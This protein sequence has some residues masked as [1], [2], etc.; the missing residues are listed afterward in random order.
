MPAQISMCDFPD[1]SLPVGIMGRV[2]TG[3]LVLVGLALCEGLAAQDHG[4]ASGGDDP[5]RITDEYLPLAIDSFPDRPRP[6]LEL[7]NP[8]LGPGPL[9]DPILSPTGAFWNPSLLVWGTLRSGVTA[10]DRGNNDRSQWANRLD[11][12]AEARLSSTER[13]VVGLRPLDKDGE[14]TGYDFELDED[15]DGANLDVQ[16]AFIEGDFGEIFPGLDRDDASALD[17]GFGVGRQ[18]VSF[19]DGIMVNDVMDALTLTRNSIRWN[20]VSN[21]RATALFAW[22]EVH[23]GRAVDDEDSVIVGLLTALDFVDNYV[24]ADILFSTSSDDTIGDAINIGVG[25]TQRIGKMNSTFRANASIASED[26]SAAAADGLLLTSV[27]SWVPHHTHDNLYVA[28][29]AS[30]D[31]FTSAARGPA[32]GGPLSNIG[33]LF[34]ATGLGNVGAPISPRANEVI[35]GAVGYQQFLPPRPP[36]ADLRDRGPRGDRRSGMTTARSRAACATSKRSGSARWSFSTCLPGLMSLTT[37]FFG[38]PSRVPGQVLGQEARGASRGSKQTRAVFRVGTG[39]GPPR[40]AAT[41]ERMDK[42][43]I[44]RDGELLQEEELQPVTSIGRNSKCTIQFEDPQISRVHVVLTKRSAGYE[45]ADQGGMN[46]TYLNE[47]RLDTRETVMLKDGDVFRLQSFQVKL[48]A[49]PATPAAV[50]EPP[51]PEASPSETH[52]HLESLD[53]APAASILLTD[54]VEK[55]GSFPVWTKGTATLRVADIIKET[56][57]TNTFRLVGKEDTLF[58]YKPG[59]FVTISVEIEGKTVKRSYSISSSPSRPHTLELTVKRVPGGL[60][61]NWL[62]DNLALGDEL[63]IRGPAGKFSCFNY[64]SRRMLCIAGG[65]GI[66]PIMSMCRWIVDTTA[67]VD[68]T[69][70]YSVHIASGHHFPQGARAHLRAAQWL[71]GSSSRPLRAGW[72]PRLDR[73]DRAHQPLDAGLARAGSAGAS[74]LPLRAQAIQRRHQGRA[75]GARLSDREPAHRE[76]RCGARLRPRRQR[77]RRRARSRECGTRRSAHEEGHRDQAGDQEGGTQEGHC[78]KA[79]RKEGRRSKSRRRKAGGREGHI[80]GQRGCCS[81]SAS[82]VPAG[83]KVVFKKSGSEAVA[84]DDV[85]LLIWPS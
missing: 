12:F 19:Q 83:F 38:W 56:S 16:T 70:L 23:R 35:G 69:L 13:L 9:K 28:A 46:G 81:G 29:F 47:R 21:F 73:T 79:S 42:L 53:E 10:V 45:L 40:T 31:E 17:I 85:K 72:G 22:D 68:V 34:A 78:E 30:L 32:S 2:Q 36:A 14:F 71:G 44:E 82:P 6:I 54:L 49:R 27:L 41:E 65:S 15:T 52:V 50:A 59:Q 48:Q 62:A 84:A 76:L 18:P 25:S 55:Q 63:G 33:V 3:L 74:R 8:F 58:S 67:D 24:E 1:D 5:N 57:D 64:P 80:K 20:G 11:L 60:V 77:G 37:R 4:E 66:T 61:S 26:D 7:G 51:T 43:I 39:T 75:Q